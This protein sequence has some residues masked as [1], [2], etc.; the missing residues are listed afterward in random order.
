[1]D[2]QENTNSVKD[3]GSE[4]EAVQNQSMPPQPTQ[5]EETMQ[6]ATEPK[7]RDHYW[8]FILLIMAVA[9]GY[10]VY[11]AY[12]KSIENSQM[13]PSLPTVMTTEPAMENEPDAM[14]KKSDDSMMSPDEVSEDLINEIDAIDQTDID[15]TTGPE[16]M[17]EIA[18]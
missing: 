17:D 9:L 10:G 18:Q 3:P 4:T 6:Q 16:V 15:T 12:Q 8:G 14:E 5:S 7:K 11:V 1:M 13:T 2:N